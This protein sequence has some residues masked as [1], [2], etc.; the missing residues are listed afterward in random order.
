[1][2]DKQELQTRMSLLRGRLEAAADR[3]GRK[4]AEIDLLAVSKT[5]S[6]A[7]IRLAAELG[8]RLFGENYL[9]EALPKIQA[10]S[11][12]NLQWHFIGPLQSN[13]TRAVASHFHWV[14][15]VDRLRIARRLSEQRPSAMPPLQVCLQ[16]NIDAEPTKSG[17]SPEEAA[18]LARA[19]AN[20][21]NLRL[22]GL[23]AV[24][25]PA[26]DLQARRRPFARLRALLAE[27][28]DTG[29]ELDTLSMGMSADL[30]AAVAEGSTLVRIGTDFFGPRT[31]SR[32]T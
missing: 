10:L 1:M 8:Q 17:A 11:P 20:L 15:S 28:R 9:Q 2:L 30:E 32:P 21:P 22:R 25:R 27:L 24:P 12:L 5:R 26:G 13:K 7:D 18:D 6:A 31:G 3:Y 4:A 23:M 29:L 14:H 19:V 16:I